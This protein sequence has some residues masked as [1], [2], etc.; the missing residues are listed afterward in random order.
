MIPRK[1]GNCAVCPHY[2]SLFFSLCC[3]TH[4]TS[5]QCWQTWL[6][7]KPTD[8]GGR[9]RWCAE[10]WIYSSGSFLLIESIF[11]VMYMSRGLCTTARAK[12]TH[13]HIRAAYLFPLR[14]N[15][16]LSVWH[17]RS[18]EEQSRLVSLKM[19]S[20]SRS[21]RRC[22]FPFGDS[23]QNEQNLTLRLKIMNQ[24]ERG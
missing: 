9:R 10:T 14:L 23:C 8:R 2:F 24:D 15:A 4:F 7:Y 12:H 3:L 22:L 19:K 20:L 11:M 6:Q 16:D 21:L 1:T 17:C 13:T 5:Q 18:I